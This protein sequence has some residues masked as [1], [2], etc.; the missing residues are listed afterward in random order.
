ML[1]ACNLSLHSGDTIE[2]TEQKESISRQITTEVSS[3]SVSISGDAKK[4]EFGL[5]K[6][7]ITKD[8]KIYGWAHINFIEKLGIWD[9]YND[10]AVQN[11][12]KNSYAVNLHV[13]MSEYLQDTDSLSL[14][15]EPYL[16][17]GGT[18]TG[19]PCTI[20]WSGFSPVA[21]LYKQNQ[22]VDVEVNVQ[23]YSVVL[24]DTTVLRLDFSSASSDVQFDS[25]CIKKKVLDDAREGSNILTV[26][27]EKLIES[28]NGATYSLK[29][30]DVFREW[31][32]ADREAGLGSKEVEFYDFAYRVKYVTGTTNEREVLTFDSFNQ[33]AISVPCKIT[34]QADTDSTALVDN[35]PE[36]KRLL[37]SNKTDTDYYVNTEN[38][39]IKVG[40]KETIW[41]NR[42]VPAS[43]NVPATYLRFSFEFPEEASARSSEELMNFNG[44][45]CI[46]QIPISE[47]ELEV[48][49]K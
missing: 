10:Q 42:L 31:H 47:R 20:G 22:E 17:D 16:V 23:P 3:E 38:T 46:W 48:K 24:T 45:Y 8:G 27:D 32:K 19:V 35:V 30:K 41:C 2:S 18:V 12:V 21:E 5:E 15:C 6:F 25:V 43:T 33:N 34:V 44:R 11:G 36:A 1:A 40:K 39:A 29:M 37:W 28:I 49:P 14:Q 9:Q 7:P 26:D 13:D 4:A